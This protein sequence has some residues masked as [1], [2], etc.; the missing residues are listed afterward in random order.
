MAKSKL[1]ESRPVKAHDLDGMFIYH[2]KKNRVVYSNPFTKKGWII[3]DIDARDYL[4]YSMRIMYAAFGVLFGFIFF[5]NVLFAFI[6]GLIVYLVTTGFFVFKFLP[7][8]PVIENFEKPEQ[9]PYIIRN[10]KIQTKTSSVLMMIMAFSMGIFLIYNGF[11]NNYTGV[12]LVCDLLLAGIALVFGVLNLLVLIYQIKH[13]EVLS[14]MSIKP[15]KKEEK[16]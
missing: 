10:A 15:K 11:H 2:D 6:V 1:T 9:E 5:K 12:S 3:N 8:L 4:Q 13:P 16:K 14:N 7:R